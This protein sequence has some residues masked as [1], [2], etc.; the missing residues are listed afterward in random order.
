MLKELKPRAVFAH[1]PIDINADHVMAGAAAMKALSMAGCSPE[2]EIYFIEQEYQAKRFVPDQFVDITDVL[3]RKCE[4]IRLYK[5]QYR[6]GG[7]ERR[8]CAIAKANGMHSLLLSNGSAE[9]FMSFVQPLQGQGKTIFQ[10]M[11]PSKRSGAWRFQGVRLEG[12]AK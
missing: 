4:L 1:W 5:C 6:D 2:M 8:K 7:I 11:S 3:E 12:V 10:E 9:G